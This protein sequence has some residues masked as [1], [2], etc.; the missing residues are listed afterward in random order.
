MSDDPPT[1]GELA[2]KLE[3][4]R[5]RRRNIEEEVSDLRSENEELQKAFEMLRREV[6]ALKARY[7]KLAG[8]ADGE[9]S[10]A[11]KRRRDLLIIL[12]RKAR[13]N[14]GV[15]AMDYN[16]VKDDLAAHGHGRIEDPQAYRDLRWIAERVGGCTLTNHQVSGNEA[17]EIDLNDY[18]GHSLVESTGSNNV[19][20]TETGAARSENIATPELTLNQT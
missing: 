7:E 17:V 18:H 20:R 12:E 10:T 2:G 19:S 1:R 3:A 8:L 14:G 15:F 4:E 13:R 6:T 9:E 11:T 5:G 16:D